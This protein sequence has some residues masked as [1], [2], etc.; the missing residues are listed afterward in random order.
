MQFSGVVIAI[1][2]FIVLNDNGLLFVV[3][4]CKYKVVINEGKAIKL[5]LSGQI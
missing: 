5:T 3:F 2:A 1:S 4:R